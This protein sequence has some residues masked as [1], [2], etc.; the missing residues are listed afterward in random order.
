MRIT[1]GNVGV[2]PVTITDVCIG[3]KKKYA[4]ITMMQNWVLYVNNNTLPT[5]LEQGQVIDVA[6]DRSLIAPA[7]REITHKGKIYIKVDE[8]STG[9]NYYYKTKWRFKEL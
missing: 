5:R 7:L 1:V 2:R 6:V 4:S 9:R 8:A 3:N